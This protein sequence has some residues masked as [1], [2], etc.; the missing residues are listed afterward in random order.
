MTPTNNKPI[1]V[2]AICDALGAFLASS[3]AECMRSIAGGRVFRSP[4]GAGQPADSPSFAEVARRVPGHLTPSDAFQRVHPDSNA[5]PLSVLSTALPIAETIVAHNA[6]AQGA[7]SDSWFDQR[8][9]APK[10]FDIAEPFVLE[11]FA[12]RGVRAVFVPSRDFFAF[13]K[14]DAG[15]PFSNWS[16]RHIAWASGLGT[17][18]IHGGMIT[19]EAG[20]AHRLMSYI[21]ECELAPIAHVSEDPFGNCLHRAEGGC[22]ECIPRC[23][24]AAITPEHGHDVPRCMAQCGANAEICEQRLGHRTG[25]CALCMAGVPCSTQNPRNHA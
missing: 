3:D 16:E 4:I 22:G 11:Y 10:I 20:A 25:A 9:K 13:R 14:T 5:A 1:Q 8:W 17:F 24:A 18:G 2:S 12:A 19:N 6:A 15:A 7:P 21:V 23:P